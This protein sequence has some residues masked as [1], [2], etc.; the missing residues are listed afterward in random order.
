MYVDFLLLSDDVSRFEDIRFQAEKYVRRVDLY[1]AMDLHIYR[2][3]YERKIPNIRPVQCVGR[4]EDI[5]G[6]EESLKK[7]AK[8]SGRN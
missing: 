6:Y 5:L 2:D 7:L 8:S 4:G 1:D 3:R